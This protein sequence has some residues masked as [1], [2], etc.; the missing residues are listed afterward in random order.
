V[1]S[2]SIASHAGVILGLV[3]KFARRRKWIVRSPLTD[4]PLKVPR[5]KARND[6]PTVQ[7]VFELLEFLST[8]RPNDQL[9]R[10]QSSFAMVAMAIFTGMRAGEIAG[11]L[12]ENVDLAKGTI[13]VRH[14]LS[15]YD[16]LKG[17]KTESGI[18]ELAI[19]PVLR[20]ALIPIAKRAGW[21]TTGYVFTTRT[22]APM[23]PGKIYSTYFAPQMR[24]LGLVDGRGRPKFRFHALRHFYQSVVSASGKVSLVDQAKLMGHTKETMTIHYTHSLDNTTSAR[25]AAEAVGRALYGETRQICD[26]RVEDAE[27][28]EEKN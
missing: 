16:G 19:H 28:I 4:D 8:L 27:I 23:V 21:P 15:K 13:K 2:P 24:R 22:G 14:S 9:R 26:N 7:D 5:L 18:R 10:Q 11:L 20:Q 17:P 3:L 25:L 1:I 12:W 6:C